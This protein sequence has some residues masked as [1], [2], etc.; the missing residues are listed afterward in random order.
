MI[1]VFNVL[2]F[3]NLST[4]RIPEAKQKRYTIIFR[5]KLYAIDDKI[6]LFGVSHANAVVGRSTGNQEHF[7]G[8]PAREFIMDQPRAAVEQ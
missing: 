4:D 5:N 3:L 8:T 2:N 7:R 6:Y 1:F